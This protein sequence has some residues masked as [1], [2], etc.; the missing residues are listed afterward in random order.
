MKDIKISAIVPIYNNEKYLKECID[1]I[2]NQTLLDIEIICIDNA[3]KDNSK[4]ILNKY[5]NDSRVNL[6]ELNKNYGAGEAR[7][8]G[9]RV[10]KGEFVCFMDSDDYYYSNNI[11]ETLYNK[12]K[13]KNVDICGGNILV[14]DMDLMSEYP[15]KREFFDQEK[16]ITI[17]EY[18]EFGGYFRFIYK[19]SV[20]KENNI[21]F[22]DYFR[23]QDPVWFY[24][25]MTT[26]SKVY[27]VT[28]YI[29]VYR[30]SHKTVEWNDRQVLDAIKS[31]K[32]N[33]KLLKKYRLYK[34]YRLEFNDIKSK[35]LI[36]KEQFTNKKIQKRLSNFIKKFSFNTI[37]SVLCEDLL[38]QIEKDKFKSIIEQ[39]K[40]NQNRKPYIII[41]FGTL[42]QVLYKYLKDNNLKLEF[43]FDK[44]IDG[45]KIN[46]NLK[47]ISTNEIKNLKNADKYMI[48]NTILNKDFIQEI[49]SSFSKIDII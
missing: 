43:I 1:T 29:Y 11:L 31:Y 19:T 35:L 6:I 13:E 9:L 3:S 41:G 33:F 45:F 30:I 40:I 10:A 36:K 15:L 26:V 38:S 2:V 27:V 18:I 24:K 20:I 28:Q 4:V 17:R 44:A 23:R 46:D 12:A 8:I 14:K 32:D 34:H 21:F 25:M 47:V 22:P 49:K 5:K 42:G 37:E 7:N 16:Y 48:I 39:I